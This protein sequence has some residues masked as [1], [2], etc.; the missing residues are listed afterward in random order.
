MLVRVSL[1]ARSWSGM[2]TLSLPLQQQS[3]LVNSWLEEKVQVLTSLW[4]MVVSLCLTTKFASLI[5]EEL[6]LILLLMNWWS[7][8]CFLLSIVTLVVLYPSWCLS[9]SVHEAHACSL[10]QIVSLAWRNWHSL[11]CFNCPI[12]RPHQT[13]KTLPSSCFSLLL[14]CLLC[15]KFCQYG[16]TL[17]YLLLDDFFFRLDFEGDCALVTVILSREEFMFE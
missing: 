10:V 13:L 16:M 15:T 5:R 7:P 6:Q 12:S 3:W 17:L 2:A 1:Y 14:L 4:H 8:S 11:V 9:F